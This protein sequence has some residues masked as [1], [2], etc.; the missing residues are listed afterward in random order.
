MS[1]RIDALQSSK[2]DHGSHGSHPRASCASTKLIPR[3]QAP[4]SKIWTAMALVNLSQAQC[5]AM[6]QQAD[7]VPAVRPSP[8]DN[9][10]CAG[11][12]TALEDV[13]QRLREL[14][15]QIST[16]KSGDNIGRI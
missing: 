10:V 3:R 5:V 16:R 13:S 8:T 1:D 6:A 11:V 12:V 7:R 9:A 2:D 14:V 15:G 4:R